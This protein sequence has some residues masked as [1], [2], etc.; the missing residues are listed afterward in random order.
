MTTGASTTHGNAWLLP[1]AVLTALAATAALLLVPNAAGLLPALAILPGWMIFAALMACGYGFVRCALTGQSPTQSLRRY[2]VEQRRH[3][4]LTSAIVLLAG[5][6]M[7][8]FMWVKTL[9]NYQV[10]FWADPY[11]AALDHTLF[12]GHE[13]WALL[14]ALDFKGAGLIYHPMWFILLIFALLMAA[15]AQPGRERS[16]VLLSYFVLWTVIG[17]LVHTLLPAA[18]PIFFERMGYGAR[19]AAVSSSAEVKQ[20]GDYLWDIYATKRFGAGSGISAMPSMH[21]AMSSWTV[22]AFRRFAPRFAFVA[23]GGWV[24]IVALSIALGWHY[25]CDGIAGSLVA[26]ATYRAIRW[27]LRV[28]TGASDQPAPALTPQL[29]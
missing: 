27:A 16:A 23:I 3:V 8:S 14:H 28:S 13:P 19:F 12:L 11:L 26:V 1:S 20:V 2:L 17:P 21:V 22:I 24:V 10:D 6:N 29:T 7:V 15:A 4:L 9:L 25:A 18:G 5:L